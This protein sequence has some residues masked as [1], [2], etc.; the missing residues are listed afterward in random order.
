MTT[1]GY[2]EIHHYVEHVT[3]LLDTIGAAA[4]IPAGESLGG[5]DVPLHRISRLAI[6]SSSLD[7][8]RP[9]PQSYANRGLAGMR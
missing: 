1:T 2:T 8:N 5:W 9:T 3:H 7:R 4:G 6:T